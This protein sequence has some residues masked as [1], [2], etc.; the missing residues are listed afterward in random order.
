MD[1]RRVTSEAPCPIAI[2]ARAPVAG[3]A[4][5]RLIPRLGPE[6]AARLH[7][8][9][10]EHTLQ[11]ALAAGLGEVTLWCAPDEAHPFFAQCAARFGVGLR[12][13]Q[14]DDLGAR[15]L[16]AFEAARGPLIVIGADCPMLGPDLLREAD[17]ALRAGA[18]AVLCPADDGGYGLIGL[19]QPHASLFENMDWGTDRVMAETRGRLRTLGLAWRET[20]PVWDVDRPE[21]LDK[22]GD[23]PHLLAPRL[24]PA[25]FRDPR[26]TAKGERRARVELH[27][28][29][30]LWINTGTLCNIACA[31]CYIESSP[32]ND[33][34]EYI[35]ARETADYLDEIARDRLPVKLIGF[36]GGEPFM[37]RELRA[38]L[39]DA[40]S[41]GFD[42]LVLTNAMKPMQQ[43]RDW[44][45]D[46]HAR[47][48]ARLKL[49]VSL[50]YFN[51]SWHE[52]ERGPDTFAPTI[53][54]LRWLSE[55]GLAL[56][57]AGRLFSGESEQDLRAGY[58]ALFA[59][60]G[61]TVDAGDPVALMLFPEMDA[62]VDV[63]EITDACWGILH[64]S[65]ADVMC[66]T[67][68]MVVKRKGAEA[69]AVL[70]C[71]LLAYDERFELGRTL[72]EASG[73]VALNHPHCAKFCVLGGAACSR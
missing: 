34:L 9:L 30:T 15:M 27:A 69:P 67:S 2:F 20:A 55:N 23:F 51:S 44:L 11:Q 36:T 5:T 22:L 13:Q 31:N 3:A 70:A 54:G 10:V 73:A 64:K 25:K 49:R 66:A 58:A 43:A 7:A 4:K 28:L 21:D 32:R 18:D 12:T 65:P 6:G 19:A 41:R 45:L 16:F 47:Y 71:T 1:M 53:A 59:R 14:G 57:V 40:L 33:R 62:D 52:R 38:M 72:K 8:R 68:R 46:L 37:N 42:A 24:D 39:E 61:V 17:S 35:S 26:V 56:D 50:D 29:E 60:E 48:G 63:P